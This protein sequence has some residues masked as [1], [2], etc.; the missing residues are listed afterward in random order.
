M[1]LEFES[2][3]LGNGEFIEDA[4]GEVSEDFLEYYIQCTVDGEDIY[5]SPDAIISFTLKKEKLKIHK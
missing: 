1:K 3:A 2:I 4:V 5:V